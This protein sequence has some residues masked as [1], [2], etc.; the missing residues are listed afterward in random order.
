MWVATRR[1][2]APHLGALEACDVNTELV[3]I[4][5]R[6]SGHQDRGAI[7]VAMREAEVQGG[8]PEQVWHAEP[9]AWEV[10]DEG[11]HD[12][13]MA[14][15]RRRTQRRV[16]NMIAA[17]PAGARAQQARLPAEVHD[18]ARAPVG[19][20]GEQERLR[21]GVPVERRDFE[22]HDQHVEAA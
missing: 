1:L 21:A 9:V 18:D 5:L 13:K 12:T 20:R 16:A 22:E 17:A 14:V 2:G 6:A 11:L 4:R 7:E 10:A 3:V 8:L 15:P 19:G